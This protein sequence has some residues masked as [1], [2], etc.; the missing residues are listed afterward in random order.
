MTVGSGA[1]FSGEWD[2]ILNYLAR[3]GLSYNETEEHQ[4]IGTFFTTYNCTYNPSSSS[5][6][7]YLSVYGWTVEP[8][9]EFYIIEDWRNW[10]P[11]MDASAES[12][13][14]I[15]VNGSVYDIIENTRINQPSIKGI[16]TFQQY[17]SI[18]R[19]TR[20]SGT[21]NISDHFNA[22]ETHGMNMGKMY[23][24]SFV[25]EGYESS[26]NFEFTELEVTVG[27]NPV[28]VK[29][30]SKEPSYV[31]IFPNPTSGNVSVKIDESIQKAS[32]K[33]YDAAGRIVY[34]RD[35]IN[36]NLLQISN[37]NSGTYF[38][39]VNSTGFNYTKKIQVL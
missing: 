6:N 16:T 34:S 2:G 36:N 18:R 4:E 32:L 20:N 1:L 22:W 27:G 9:V 12:R 38:I 5:G 35:K 31:S 37:L 25:V 11:S 24:V 33:I 13:G 3:R 26:G 10:I 21:I 14:T 29:E 17:F 8:L 19:N 39:H 28:Q 7:S 30:E 23:E 15:E